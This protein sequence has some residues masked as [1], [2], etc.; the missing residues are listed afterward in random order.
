MIY[1]YIFLY[2]YSNDNSLN[3][4]LKM[5]CIPDIKGLKELPFCLN[6][7]MWSSYFK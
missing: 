6:F 2:V 4:L 5:K 3:T 1:V 7:Q